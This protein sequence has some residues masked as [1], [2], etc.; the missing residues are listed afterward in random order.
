[1][2]RGQ[3][4]VILVLVFAV[5]GSALAVVH[6]KFNSRQLF[7]SQQMLS[8]Q[9][10]QADIVWGQLQLELATWATHGRVERLARSRLHMR[11]PGPDE[12]MVIG[13]QHGR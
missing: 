13:L 6:T 9:R 12:V 8:K 7:V 2:T 1:M 10:D 5:V 11:L 3:L 4:L